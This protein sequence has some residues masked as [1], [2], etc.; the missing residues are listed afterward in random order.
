[1]VNCYA[2]MDAGER[3]R[4][5]A[6]LP[7]RF[8]TLRRFN[9]DLSHLRR[10][11]ALIGIP[12]A[13]GVA[14]YPG[15]MLGVVQAR[16]FWN[17]SLVA[18]L[19]IVSAISTGC[20]VLILVAHKRRVPPAED[21]LVLYSVNGLLL[22]I[23]LVIVMA[24]VMWG[25]VS[26]R[27]AREAIQLIL[28]GSFTILFWICFVGLG[29]VVPLVLA[30]REFASQFARSVKAHSYPAVPVVA[31]VLV[32]VGAYLLRCIFVFAGQRSSI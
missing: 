23:E 11:L 22:A 12:L 31:A 2:W 14:L 16:P 9:R 18:Q 8:A 19:F 26:L 15:L 13:L 27:P 29:V 20:A 32:V 24:F 1:L 28:G 10:R 3:A 25:V 6:L 7:K 4:L 5:F 30:A 21:L 17:S